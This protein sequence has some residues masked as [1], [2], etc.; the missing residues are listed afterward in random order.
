[1]KIEQISVTDL[2]QLL[3]K[4]PG[5]FVLVDV[6]EADELKI[7]KITQ[8]VHVPLGEILENRWNPPAGKRL[9]MQCRSGKRSQTAA[10][11]LASK[12]HTNVANIAGGI[13]DWI[14]K[15]DPTQKPY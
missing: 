15:V 10:E 8:S 6:R 2:A 1:M 9:L 3:K 12:G 14:A 11:H 5:D 7:C 13:L 4:N